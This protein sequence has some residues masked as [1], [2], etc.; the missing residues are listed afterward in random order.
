MYY[1]WEPFSKTMVPKTDLKVLILIRNI[2]SV[3]IFAL[4]LTWI[5]ATRQDYWLKDYIEPTG[6]VMGSLIVLCQFLITRWGGGQAIEKNKFYNIPNTREHRDQLVKAKTFIAQGKPDEAL[7][8]LSA[9]KVESVTTLVVLLSGRWAE[10]SRDRIRD[11]LEHTDKSFQQISRD[12]LSLISDLEVE[13][14]TFGEVD[15]EVRAYLQ[16]RYTNRLTQ[17]LANRQPINLR[18]LP[19]TEGTSDET[20]NAFVAINADEIKAHIEQVFRK[21]YGR[22]LITGKPGAGKTILLL[23][24]EL[25]LLSSE[26]D[27][28]PVVLNLATWKKDYVTLEP[29]LQAILPA[30]L[31]VSKKYAADVLQQK[32]LILLLDGLDEVEETDRAACLDAIGRF[33]AA[34]NSQY[35][36]TSRIGEYTAISK[37]APVN[38]QIEVGDLTFEQMEAELLRLGH[39]QAETMPL[40]NAL[41][42]YPSL[43]KAAQVPFYFN[44]LQL[45]FASGKTL[46]DLGLKGSTSEEIQA[47]LTPQFVSYALT[48][49]ANNKYTPQQA[50]HWLSFLAQN[51]TQRNKVVFEL[52]DLQYD[53][54]PVALSKRQLKFAH[55]VQTIGDGPDKLFS[56]ILS[57]PTAILAYTFGFS[58]AFGLLGFFFFQVTGLLI[59]LSFGS[60]SGFIF[61][62][63]YLSHIKSVKKLNHLLINT[64]EGTKISW[65]SFLQNIKKQHI[66]LVVMLFSGGLAAF[67]LLFLSPSTF[68]FIYSLPVFLFFI[69]LF[70]LTNLFD[71]IRSNT[72]TSIQLIHPYQR[73][74]NSAKMLHFAIS[75]HW[76]LMCILSQKGWLPWRIVPFLNDMVAQQVLESPDGA[77]WRFR[78]RIL[79]E[80]FTRKWKAENQAETGM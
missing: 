18:R 80:H 64:V 47:E 8:V 68:V 2:L 43:R 27:L 71:N 1:V 79:Q 25:A 40:L 32:R 61:A 46:S 63:N 53:W 62:V 31:G 22:L 34:T 57:H 5:W 59:G 51:M 45:L 3:S 28:L 10:Y 24:L 20:A 13:I 77:T 4:G 7:K 48:I 36:I 49:P 14:N 39:Q 52:A 70:L 38:L 55:W 74:I 15:Q 50:E 78:H 35:V 12:I 17:K 67:P 56:S 29:W 41:K 60:F 9:I 66:P 44:T 72:I 19:T 76:H 21:A 65:S 23:Q 30:E 11:V 69:Y 33:R 73:F 54:Y 26:I 75:Q 37:D 16:K 42:K 58:F 6:M